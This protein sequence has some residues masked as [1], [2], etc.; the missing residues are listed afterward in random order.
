M[1]VRHEDTTKSPRRADEPL[2]LPDHHAASET[3]PIR[4]V[5]PHSI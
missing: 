1:E 2:H 5:L 4:F 3:S